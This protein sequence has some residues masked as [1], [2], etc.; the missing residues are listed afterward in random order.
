MHTVLKPR[1]L[2]PGDTI[3]VISPS[4][5]GAG[6]FPHR[7]DAAR[8]QLA[9]MGLQLRFARH[10][11][12]SHGYVSDSPANRAS[13]VHELFADP[14]VAAI[15]AGIG[16][17]HSCQLLPH[18]DFELIRAHPKV[19][20]GYSDV[21]VLNVALWQ[22]TGLV[23]FNGPALIT[24]F[25]EHPC[26]PEYSE[27]YFRALACTP[28]PPGAIEPAAEWTEEILSWEDQVDLTRPRALTPSPGW[29]WLKPGRAEGVLIGGCIE[30]LQ[31]LRGTRFWPDFSGALLFLETSEEKPTPATID[32]ILM[33]YENMGVL[34]QLNGLLV[35]R[36]MFY[37][38][39][40]KRELRDV[41]LERTRAFAFPIVCD[42][43]FGHTSPQM[44]LPL[45]V[46]ARIDSTAQR[47]EIIEAAT[48][49]I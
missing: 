28:S 31:H 45:G 47:F 9:A 10:A 25:G 7:C 6:L 23:T 27:R 39:E 24:D 11:L 21:T 41:L 29:S 15:V 46:C 36:P 17:D 32:G 1:A 38:D 13:D 33:D 37:S 49:E 2:R 18:L 19:F 16:G 3:G 26:M 12:N 35:G 43:D 22:Q 4:W 44:T 48:L 5:G 40:E 8:R 34:A 42:M 30:S 20:M 14:G